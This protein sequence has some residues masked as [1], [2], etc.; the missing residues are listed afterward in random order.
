MADPTVLSKPYTITKPTEQAEDLDRMLDELY[1]ALQVGQ[2][3]ST[4]STSSTSTGSTGVAGVSLAQ[5]SARI[6]HEL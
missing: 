4:S 5:V 2:V 6:L 3:S 1:R